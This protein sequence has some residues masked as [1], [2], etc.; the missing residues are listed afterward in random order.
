MTATNGA[1]VLDVS[2]EFNGPKTYQYVATISGVSSKTEGKS[3][4][5]FFAQKSATES[6]SKAIYL[7]VDATYQTAD[8]IRKQQNQQQAKPFA[9]V[10]FRLSYSIDNLLELATVDGKFNM[11]QTPKVQKYM[12]QMYNQKSI[13]ETPLYPNTVDHID[14]EIDYKNAP[15]SVMEKEFGVKPSNVYNYIRYTTI[16][17]LN[18]NSEYQGQQ[19]KLAFEVRF[20][21]DMKSANFTFKAPTVKTEWN[22][23]RVPLMTKNF[24]VV[25]TN[26]NL[27]EE[28][29]REFIQY[30]D[31]CTVYEQ[32]TNTFE[33]R[34]VKHGALGNTWHLAVHKMREDVY[35]KQ[36]NQQNENKKRVHYV[37]VLVRDAQQSD[38]IK[39][40]TYNFIDNE[41]QMNDEEKKNKE[42]LIVLHQKKHNDITVQLSPRNERNNIPRFYVDGQEQDL[43]QWSAVVRST[44]NHK[45]VLAR[46]YVTERQQ[47]QQQGQQNEVV[48]SLRVETTSG[49]LEIT[50]DGKNV[51]IRSKSFARNNRGICGSFNGQN[52]N[53]MKSPE[54]KI[55]NND[56]EFAASWAIVDENSNQDYTVNTLK[57]RVQQKQYPTEEILYS[58]PVPKIEKSQRSNRNQENQR[59]QGIED[60]QNWEERKQNMNSNKPVQTGTKHQTQFVEDEYRQKICFTIRP[61]PVCAPGSIANGKTIKSV[62]VYCRDSRDPAAQQY[63]QQIQQGRNMDMTKYTAND[64]KK[65][66]I[67][68]RCERQL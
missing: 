62:E 7:Q 2:V 9:D 56:K 20:A 11:K 45:E 60:A 8:D 42:V 41:S 3:R 51:Q 66:Y 5:L 25:P 50:Y 52:A 18:E 54:N 35:A 13:V 37:S 22:G 63:K 31:T 28:L 30:H 65:F 16:M 17:Y 47:H 39:Q 24:A 14:V 67:P 64:N 68:K 1:D 38:Q 40:K 23:L 21:P 33:N 49:K 58:S 48:R 36:Q 34:T 19:D 46:V 12:Q 10:K 32:E 57:Q 53:E 43:S 6:Q 59:E 4:V 55:I 26:W 44:E 15:A 27:L 61:L 29:K